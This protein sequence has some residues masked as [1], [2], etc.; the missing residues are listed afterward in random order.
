M[1]QAAPIYWIAA[2]VFAFVIWADRFQL[3]ES[4]RAQ[5]TVVPAG[6]VQVVKAVDG[7]VLAQLLVREG[8]QVEVGQILARLE[9]VRANARQGEVQA[10]LAALEVA[11]ERA[12]AEAEQREPDFDQFPKRWS[13]MVESQRALYRETAQRHSDQM[14]SLTQAL[15]LAQ[16][17]YELLSKL[18][19]SGDTSDMRLLEAENELL[20]ARQNLRAAKQD[21]KAGALREVAEIESRLYTLQFQLNER[22]NVVEKTTITAPKSGIVSNLKFATLGAPIGS[23]ETL[24]SISPTQE[25][26][27]LEIKISPADVGSLQ[28]GEPVSAKLSAFDATVYGDFK[29]Q[30]ILISAEAV[31]E[32]VDG[33]QQTFFKGVARMDWRQNPKVNPDL[34]R[35]GM[36]ASVDII[37]GR[38][39]VLEYLLKPIKRGMGQAL[40][41]R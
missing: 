23:G 38:R 24:L 3:D 10:Q 27:E 9:D 26:F 8:D 2:F 16:A 18:E 29:G 34:L 33:T 41:E 14:T 7:G 21:F 6:R 12:G 5:A 37:T 11:L 31:S 35:A 36:T 25:A 19:R 22:A 39:S 1:R 4:V 32:S 15:E 13:A 28:V 30:L 40:T 20:T 17:R